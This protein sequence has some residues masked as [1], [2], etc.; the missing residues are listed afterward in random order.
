MGKARSRFDLKES[1]DILIEL[2]EDNEFKIERNVAGMEHAFIASY[3]SGSPVI[4]F[5]GNMTPYLILARWPMPRNLF[6]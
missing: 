5:L 6:P 1:A 3:G 2:L 4:G